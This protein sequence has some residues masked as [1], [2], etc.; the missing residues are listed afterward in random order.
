M[1]GEDRGREERERGGRYGGED[2][3]R[4]GKNGGGG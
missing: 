4:G 3:G 2:R 1:E